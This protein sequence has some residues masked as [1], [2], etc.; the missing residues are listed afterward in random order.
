M[1]CSF[2][3]RVIFTFIGLYTALIIYNQKCWFYGNITGCCVHN[4]KF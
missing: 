4:S 3:W 2:Y 1:S